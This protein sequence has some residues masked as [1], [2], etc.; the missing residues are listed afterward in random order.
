[1]N[2]TIYP[3]PATGSLRAIPSKS[4]AHRLLICAALGQRPVYLACAATSADIDATVRCLQALGAGIH[5][6][7]KGFAVTPLDRSALPREP[8]LDCGESGSTFRFLLPVAAALGVPARFRLAGRLP[9][10]PLSPLDRELENHGCSL[11]WPEAGLLLCRGRLTPGEFRLPGNVSSQFLSGLLFALPLLEGESRL[12]VTGPSQSRGYVDMTLEALSQFGCRP[13]L[14]G[15]VYTVRPGAYLGPERLT[16]EGD[17]SNAAFF[18]C[19]GAMPRGRVSLRGLPYPTCQ[20]DRAIA[21]LLVQMG[22]RLTVGQSLVCQSGSRR[23]I[24]LDA[25]DVPDLVPAVAA[26]AAVCRGTTVIT[27]A[28]RLKLKESDRLQAIGQTL[29]SLG[30][31]VDIQPDGLILHGVRQLQG[32]TVD[33]WGDHRIAMMAAVASCACTGPVTVLGAQA[34]E[35]S[36]PGFWRDLRLLGKSCKVEEGL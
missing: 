1:M 3:G 28:R 30:A 25:A 31:D 13:D 29:I 12:V 36:Y 22:A 6:D 24:S 15:G 7:G 10:R 26:L 19:A 33:A 16:V 17:W 2:V 35:K 4:H 18:L 23:A 20:G 34:V 27:N 5:Y 21:D 14:S 9:S 8:E 11:S 32:G